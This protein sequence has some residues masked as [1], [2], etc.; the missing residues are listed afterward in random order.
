M[1]ELALEWRHGFVVGATL[2]A[3]NRE[4]A[5]NLGELAHRLLGLP[6][7]RFLER[8]SFGLNHEVTHYGERVND[9]APVVNALIAEPNLARLRHLEFGLQEPD[10]DEDYKG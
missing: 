7:C 6:V 10:I 1:P 9:Y 4:R 5:V 2:S 8:L 3:L